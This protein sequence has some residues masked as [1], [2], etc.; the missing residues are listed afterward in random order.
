M[1]SNP[2]ALDRIKIVLQGCSL[3]IFPVLV[4]MPSG[5]V[6]FWLSSSTLGLC[7]TLLLNN[8]STRKMLGLQPKHPALGATASTAQS[9]VHVALN[10]L[11][12]VIQ[13]VSKIESDVTKLVGPTAS[14]EKLKTAQ[15]YL[16]NQFQS[17]NLK[18]KLIITSRKDPPPNEPW[19]IIEPLEW[20]KNRQHKPT[21]PL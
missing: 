21:P 16:D 12:E 2:V 8:D 9:K 14:E 6:L 18:E 11:K 17:G 15:D 1:M 3:A 10:R 13:E 7:Q 4:N 20:N 5:L 19:F